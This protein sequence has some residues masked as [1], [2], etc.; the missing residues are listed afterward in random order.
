MGE[1]AIKKI[2]KYLFVETENIK[3]T[4]SLSNNNE[5]EYELT[6][7]IFAEHNNYKKSFV[8]HGSNT[9]YKLPNK[10]IFTLI[11]N[12]SD[13]II[14]F[15]LFLD[16]DELCHT[17]IHPDEYIYPL[18][19]NNILPLFL[20]NKKMYISSDQNL[21]IPLLRLSFITLKNY[22]KNKFY[23]SHNEFVYSINNNELFNSCDIIKNNEYFFDK[24]NNDTYISLSK[25]SNKLINIVI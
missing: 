14:N 22:A 3:S 2:I 1:K 16:D 6:N 20:L 19:N 5:Y 21:N 8:I 11:Y 23:N 7:S 25:I 10:D 12:S 4:D 24:P 17:S 15:R 18:Y 9:K 13:K